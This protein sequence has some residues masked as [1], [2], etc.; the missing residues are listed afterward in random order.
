MDEK[1]E[2]LRRRRR[3]HG[4]RRARR[5]LRGLTVLLV[6]AALAALAY[7]VATPLLTDQTQAED[8]A[9]SVTTARVT[10]GTIEKTVFGTGSVQPASQPGVYATVEATDSAFVEIPFDVELRRG[11]NEVRISGVTSPKAAFD[12]IRMARKK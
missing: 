10:R 5:M 2:S 4:R 8:T 12:C 6:L 3:M 1:Q 7:G 11:E 9:Q